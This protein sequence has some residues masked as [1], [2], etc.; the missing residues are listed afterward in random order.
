M[1]MSTGLMS[2]H[3]SESG[4]SKKLR[5]DQKQIMFKNVFKRRDLDSRKKPTESSNFQAWCR[6][7]GTDKHKNYVAMFFQFWPCQH[8]HSLRQMHS[9]RAAQPAQAL[10]A[11]N[12]VHT[13]QFTSTMLGT[14][15]RKEST[16]SNRS[17][18]RMVTKKLVM[19]RPTIKPMVLGHEMAT[20]C[21]TVQLV[22]CWIIWTWNFLL[23]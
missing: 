3:V 11:T 19:S 8:S 9:K 23:C 12:H 1:T 17:Y 18:V 7:L 2:T 13:F 22:S 16:V 20:Y 15:S 5:H 4:R 21:T 6:R 14:T 10:P